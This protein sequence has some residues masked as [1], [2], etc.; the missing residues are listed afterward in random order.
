MYFSFFY[1]IIL[2]FL[3]KWTGTQYVSVTHTVC[4]INTFS[5]FEDALNKLCGSS[6]RSTQC[7]SRCTE[8]LLSCGT[9]GVQESRLFFHM[10]SVCS[11]HRVKKLF[12]NHTDIVPPVTTRSLSISVTWKNVF[13]S[14]LPTMCEHHTRVRRSSSARQRTRSRRQFG[15]GVRRK[16]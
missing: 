6:F 15:P 11:K 8:Q 14:T 2:S 9:S 10:I 5:T 16:T 13:N 4:L 12:D 1:F 7:E 3:H